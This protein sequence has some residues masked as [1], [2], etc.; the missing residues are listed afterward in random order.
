M[1]AA[2][3]KLENLSGIDIDGDGHI[4]SSKFQRQT[5]LAGNSFTEAMS[6]YRAPREDMSI[7]GG[8]EAVPASTT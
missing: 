6:N 5:T 2:I 1:H 3:D 8:V 7:T 4:K